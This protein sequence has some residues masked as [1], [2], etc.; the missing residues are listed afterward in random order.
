[1]KRSIALLAGVAALFIAACENDVN[2]LHPW[3]SGSYY[4]AGNGYDWTADTAGMPDKVPALAACSLDEVNLWIVDTMW[5]MYLWYDQLA[6]GI[7]FRGDQEPD[8]FLHSIMYKTSDHFSYV[9]KKE[10]HDDYYSGRYY[11]FGF[12]FRKLPE[13]MVY[14]T[15]VIPGGPADTAGMRRGQRIVAID[16]KTVQE[17]EDQN[18]WGTVTSRPEDEKEIP[19][20]YIVEEAG[21]EKTLT[22]Y[23]GDVTAPS[24][25]KAATLAVGEKKVG[26]LMLKSFINS[27]NDELDAAFT[28]FKA[29]GVTELVVDLRYNGGGW[30]DGSEHL[31]SLITGGDLK[32]KLFTRLTYNGKHQDYNSD[33]HFKDYSQSLEL[34]KVVFIATGGTASASEVV[35]NGLKPY[36][37]VAIIG[38]TTYGKPVGM[39][40]MNHCDYTLVPI[41]FKLANAD[42]YGDYFDGMPADCAADDD[43][44]HDFGDPEEGSLKAAL[45]YLNDKTCPAA[46]VRSW[47]PGELDIRTVPYQM[48]WLF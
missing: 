35:I 26:Y 20:V 33:Y 29:D 22:L 16:G 21:E 4:G 42:A 7:D 11:G 44:T 6:T 25:Y 8:E 32:D 31:A 47:R 13:Y 15:L 23:A 2:R 12:G 46:T 43:V 37:E 24:I 40:P 1:M 36:I 17:I 30:L 9:A 34:T 10:A 48:G 14:V 5:D 19:I 3:G 45:S 38:D 41:T 18:L 27:T 28:K 39:N